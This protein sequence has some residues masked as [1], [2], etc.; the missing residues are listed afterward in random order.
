MNGK[1]F[2]LNI[3][4]LMI[5][6]CGPM[7][8]LGQKVFAD[9]TLKKLDHKITQLMDE[10]KIPGVSLIVVSG[11]QQMIRHYGYADLENERPVTDSTLFEIGSC[12]KAF[13]A[14]AVQQLISEGKIQPDAPVQRYIPWFNAVHNRKPAVIT[15]RHLLH[16]TSGIPWRTIASIPESAADDALENTVRQVVGIKLDNPPGKKFLYATI[17]YDV[18]ALIVQQVSGQSF[19]SYLQQQVIDRLNLANTSVGKPVDSAR[20]A[21]GYKIGFWTPRA[22]QAPV[23]RGN[24]AAGYV[25]TDARDFAT[26]M[27][28]QLGY[29]KTPLYDQAVVTHQRDETVLPHDMYDYVYDRLSSYAMGWEVSLSGNGEVYHGGLNP[30]YTAYMA[31]RAKQ[32]YGVAVLANSNST[33][34]PLIGYEV[35]KMLS[36]ETPEKSFNHDSGIDKLFST[37][38][39]VMA[40]YMLVMV[41]FAIWFVRDIINKERRFKGLTMKTLG[42]MVLLLLAMLPFVYGLYAL[43]YALMQFTWPAII[44][45]APVSFQV[46]VIMILAALAV[47]YVVFC[48]SLLFP[49]TNVYK[50][51]APQI[52]LLS[53][54]SG[55]AN[56][57]VI[58]IVTSSFESDMP[59]RFLLYYYALTLVVYLAG[60]RFVQINLIKI[61]RSLVYELKL[62]LIEKIFS[63]SYQKFE[64]ID[65]GRIY[66]ALND[67]IDTIGSSISTFI[68]LATSMFTAIGAFIYLAS[69]AFWATAIT[70]FIILSLTTIYYLVSRSTNIY[71]EEARDVQNVFMRLVNGMIDGY[72]EISLQR[73]KKL[74]YRSDVGDTAEEYKVKMNTAEIRFVN[75]FLIGELVLV[76]LLGV[77]SFGIPKLFP[78]IKSYTVMSFVV[79]LLYLIGPVNE[80]LNSVPSIMRLRIAWKRIRKFQADIPANMD[81]SA[82][83][84]Q[85]QRQVH[86][87]EALHVSYQYKSESEQHP[88]MVGPVNLKAVAGEIIFIIGGNGSGK[89]TL[90]KLLTGLYEPDSGHVLIN[91]TI[92]KPYELSE[93]Y[94]AVFSPAHLFDK[95][96]NVDLGNRSAEVQR[97]LRLLDLEEKVVIKENNYSTISL[98]GGQRK[99]LALLQCYLEDRQIFLFDEWAADQ[100]PSYRN[101]FYRV[102]LPEMKKAGKIVIAITHDDNYFD[103]ADKVFKMNRGKLEAYNGEVIFAT[104]AL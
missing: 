78:G 90:A 13:T 41:A 94:S 33:F 51:K 89:T 93:Y 15:V 22:Y 104:E 19:E 79:V 31:M 30:N 92:V 45:W 7:T 67:D 49:G 100:D 73:N 96:Y 48:V 91:D 9:S 18:L 71:F 27:K 46:A 47:S 1:H 68:M 29:L 53:I 65:R 39:L 77:V 84:P 24:Y 72:K 80:I 21:V 16:H 64:R 34:T 37:I 83:A 101:F 5:A 6:C 70:V 40:L 26:W 85:L 36:G 98:S 50:R 75:A 28:F 14:L 59:F 43:P 87:L 42:N 12:T 25:I 44:V 58:V 60:R 38:V 76:V 3:W 23:F 82:P 99:R 61:T 2:C 103:V 74:E 11:N 66:T 56:M 97:Y 20:M 62:K 52:L 54:L 17:N 102:L 57:S 81:L 35:M 86:S 95:L 69:I 8:V 63:T 4:L 10:G 55:L 88:F 32:K